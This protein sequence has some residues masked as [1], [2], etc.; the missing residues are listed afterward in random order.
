VAAILAAGGRLTIRDGEGNY[1]NPLGVT[2]DEIPDGV[3]FDHWHDA[4]YDIT[5]EIAWYRQG[6]ATSFPSNSDQDVLVS[7][8]RVRQLLGEGKTLQDL[9]EALE[10]PPPSYDV[11]PREYELVV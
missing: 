5:S 7:A 4:R 10:V 3:D 8:A 11:P 6:R 2:T 1:G 9:A